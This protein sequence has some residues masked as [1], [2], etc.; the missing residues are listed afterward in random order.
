MTDAKP[1]GCHYCGATSADLRP[2][3]PRGERVC[4]KC[5]FETPERK[6][7]T[8]ASFA[9]QL[10]AAGRVAILTDDGPATC[11]PRKIQ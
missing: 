2:Y 4:F 1:T 7:Q 9:S 8:E 6:A 10:N 5:A 3:G 11:D